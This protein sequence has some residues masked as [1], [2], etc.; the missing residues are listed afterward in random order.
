MIDILIFSK[1][2]ACQ[3]D[4]LLH[5][6]NDNFKE[7]NNI[8]ILF[9]FS[10]NFYESGYDKLMLKYPNCNWY[11]EDN[12]YNNTKNII[13][14]FKSDV[15]LFFVDDEIIIRDYSILKYLNLFYEYKNI[16]SISLRMNCNINFGYAANQIANKPNLQ[17]INSENFCYL[18]NWQT[19]QLYDE[20][21]YPAA[22]NSSIYQTQFIKNI[23]N[24]VSFKAVNSLE[25]ALLQCK[26]NF[27][28]KMIGFN[29]SKTILLA[30]NIVQTEGYNRHS[31]KYSLEFLNNKYL[32]N[33]IINPIPFY[34]INYNMVCI[35]SDYE[36]IEDNNV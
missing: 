26:S 25:I 13:N 11:E 35:E 14:S 4:L 2:R 15:C 27:K 10:N 23:I 5:S 36:F 19:Q 28:S 8:N 22:I 21:G 9:T 33:Y 30:N 7:L 20:W 32:C 3:L 17:Y 24:T 12:F 34:N 1:N 18:W 16:H 6:I 31:N 29:E